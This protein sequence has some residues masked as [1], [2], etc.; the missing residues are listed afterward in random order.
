MIDQPP[1]QG[2][3][4]IDQARLVVPGAPE[5]SLLLFRA[6]TLGPGRMPN[7]GSNMVDETGTRLLREWIQSLK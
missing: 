4:G 6:E 7:I 2:H 5:R 3:L 1:A